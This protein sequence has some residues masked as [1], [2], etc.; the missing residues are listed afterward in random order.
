MMSTR[1]SKSNHFYFFLTPKYNDPLPYQHKRTER[2]VVLRGR[3]INKVNEFRRDKVEERRS[4]N[5]TEVKG[6]RVYPCQ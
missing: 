3:E 5:L 4:S 2:F 6:R 1:V